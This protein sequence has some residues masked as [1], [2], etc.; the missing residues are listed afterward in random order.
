LERLA[1]NSGFLTFDEYY[2][3]IRIESSGCLR[4]LFD[5]GQINII[6]CT[7]YAIDDVPIIGV[8]PKITPEEALEKYLASKKISMYRKPIFTLCYH[9]CQDES[10]KLCWRIKIFAGSDSMDLI[11]N[12]LSGQ[13][14]QEISTVKRD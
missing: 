2:N 7:M 3:G 13:T 5:K 1:F 6:G 10:L 11:I 9:L 4:I 12:A 8:K 14:E